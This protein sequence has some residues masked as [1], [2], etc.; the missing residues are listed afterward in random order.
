MFAVA[1]WRHEG[2]AAAV[3]TPE[4]LA[5]ADPPVATDVTGFVSAVARYLPD[6]PTWGLPFTTF[7]NA[8]YY[9]VAP[10]FHTLALPRRTPDRDGP[11]PGASAPPT[12][13]EWTACRRRRQP[14]C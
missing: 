4:G 12:L 2:R 8:I 7:A 3:S 6:A 10:C 13:R 14:T 1:R 5:T 11:G 9:P